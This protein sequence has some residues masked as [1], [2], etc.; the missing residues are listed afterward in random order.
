M[1]TD[2]E[3]REIVAR[4]DGY[5]DAVASV[6]GRF[7]EYVMSAT[8]LTAATDGR[9]IQTQI[10]DELATW[11]SDEHPDRISISAWEV[12]PNWVRI[13]RAFFNPLF[14]TYPFG[15]AVGGE[16]L[17]VGRTRFELAWQATEMLGWLSLPGADRA[18]F[19]AYRAQ[20]AHPR[21][22]DAQAFVMH[23]DQHL[24]LIFYVHWRTE[25]L[26]PTA[27]LSSAPEISPE[28]PA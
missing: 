16:L 20:L 24:V 2:S 10:T 28:N 27:A 26:N 21:A 18:E 23:A 14:I 25:S 4:L 6:N 11:A 19:A 13:E 22:L 7:R 8:L 12:V 15:Q 9:D 1:A 17:E 5:L 3:W